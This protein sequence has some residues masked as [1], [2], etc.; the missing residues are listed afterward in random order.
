M[1]YGNIL[2][3]A[4]QITWRWKVLWILGFLVSLSGYSGASSSSSYQTDG[5]DWG[6]AGIRIPA[7]V[8]AVIAAVACLAILLA[9]ALWVLGVIARGGLI[10]GVQQ[11][12]DEGSTTLGSSWRAGVG[13]FW[14]LFGIS[15][16]TGLPGL[17]F[18]IAGLV[19]LGL[20]VAGMIMAIDAAAEVGGFLGGSA[21]LLCGGAICC[22]SILLAFVLAQIRLYAERAAMLEGLDWISAFKRGWQV[23]KDNLGPTIVLWLIFL[24]IGLIVGAV[25]VGPMFALMIP[26]LAMVGGRDPVVWVIIPICFGGLLWVILIALI[27]SVVQTFT[28]ATWTLAYRQ[29]T[30]AA[31]LPPVTAAGEA[32]GLE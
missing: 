11:V 19:V 12:E 7:E 22:G 26:F 2:T 23:L 4:W 13:R 32:T 15:I 8:W 18:V 21:L 20:L 10:A 17:I 30:G 14:T 6:P 1:D 5:G 28:S 27:S 9:I 16:L 31:V 24:V 25:I 3:R 29:L